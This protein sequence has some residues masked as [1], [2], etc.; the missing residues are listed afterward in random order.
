M[1]DARPH[2]L[3]VDDDRIL[4]GVLEDYLVRDGFE[5]T[6]ADDGPTALTAATAPQTDDRPDVVL[7]DLSRPGLDGREVFRR[8][9]ASGAAMPVIMLT[10]RGEESER[11]LGLEIGADDYVAKPCSPR[12]VVLRTRSVLRRAA[13]P[14]PAP[15]AAVVLV[16][17]DLQLD[18]RAGTARR[19]GRELALTPR[20]FALLEW[21][22]GHP[23]ELLER[24]RIL[25]DVWQWEHGDP[26]TI[27]VH[28]HRLREKVEPDPS[29]P[30]R[31]RTVWGRGYRWEPSGTEAAR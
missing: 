24:T 3:L 20:E 18:A 22:L 8:M 4:R 23:G 10:A 17:G 28:V 26:S 30:R 16:D 6:T 12:E 25:R 5:V 15:D 11:I 27:T 7:L 9:R 29:Q 2:V 14:A 1:N 19:D 31:I 21:F 13:P